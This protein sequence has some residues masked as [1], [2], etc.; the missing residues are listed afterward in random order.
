MAA[1][2][3]HLRTNTILNLQHYQIVGLCP[4]LRLDGIVRPWRQFQFTV[5]RLVACGSVQIDRP[6]LRLVDFRCDR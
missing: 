6:A 2:V 3:N 1:N 5:A 4:F